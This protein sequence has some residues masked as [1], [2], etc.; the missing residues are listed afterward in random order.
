[1]ADNS[2]ALSS[3][4][5]SFLPN[6][7]KLAPW[8]ANNLTEDHPIPSVAPPTNTFLLEKSKFII[9]IWTKLA[10]LIET[11]DQGLL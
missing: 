3:N 9:K 7:I 4:F 5:L 2:D 10:K 8:A 1:M 11:D 6:K